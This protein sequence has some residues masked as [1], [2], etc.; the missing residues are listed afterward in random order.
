MNRYVNLED[1]REI[2]AEVSTLCNAACPMCVRNDHGFNNLN[3]NLTHWGDSDHEIVFS[4]EL[5]NLKTVYFCGS[6]GDPLTQPDFLKTIEFCRKRNLSMH[7]FTNGSLRSL[8]WWNELT[9]LLTE[10]DKIIF[11]ID[12]IKTNHLYRQNTDIDKILKRLKLCCQSSVKTQWDFIPFEHNEDELELCKQTSKN[13]GVDFF[14]LRKTARFKKNDREVKNSKSG[15]VTH[16]IRP[17][18]NKELRHPNYNTLQEIAAG[19]HIESYNINCIYKNN[20]RYYVNSRLDVLPCSYIGSDLES[21]KK[22][23]DNQ[24]QIPVDFLNLRK[25]TW[26]QI[27]ENNF[28]KND[29]VESFTSCNTIG[30]CIHTCGVVSRILNQNEVV[31]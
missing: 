20:S 28:Y 11:G 17:P 19:K 1:I 6:H 14:R 12:G 5:V 7:I 16:V 4:E 15:V 18:R 30:R 25:F 13:L 9:S 22:I 27:I 10:N 2:H 31:E 24:L 26:K 29:L 8:P 21:N 23:K 3:I